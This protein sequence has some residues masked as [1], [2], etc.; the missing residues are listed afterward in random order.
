[1]SAD[2]LLS[3]LFST[4]V[5]LGILAAVFG[6]MERAFAYDPAQRRLRPELGLDL[7]FYFLQNILWVSIEVGAVALIGGEL[8]RHI[9]S[10]A[11]APFRTL[12]AA[13]Q[14]VTLL[15][16]SD[17]CIY[18]YHRASHRVPFLWAF[19]RV[20]HSVERLD[21]LAA[22]REHP[23]DGAL[24]RL[25]ANLPFLLFPVSLPVL[26]GI[27]GFRGIWAVFIHSNV[28]LPLGPL[29]PL[30]GAP[31]LHR[32]HHR[33]ADRTEHN[34]ANLAPWTD[35]LFGTYYRPPDE[36][37]DLGLPERPRKSYVG[38]ILAPHRDRW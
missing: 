29:R 3:T 26:A 6:L 17:L 37:I 35:L 15:A 19:H 22:H 12:P 7:A 14:L 18:A 9:P 23:V 11:V 36:P 24:T 38:W 21:W 28:R 30:L 8:Q 25:F 5:H 32:W 1:M 33:R 27:A 34:F 20:H 2:A 13:I 4:V 16:A 31:E 10:D